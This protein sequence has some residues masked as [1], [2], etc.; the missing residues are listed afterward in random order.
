MIFATKLK[1]IGFKKNALSYKRDTMYGV[2][3]VFCEKRSFDEAI[4]VS[5]GSFLSRIY[6]TVWQESVPKIPIAS[7]ATIHGRVGL[8]IDGRDRWYGPEFDT[9]S[10]ADEIARALDE[11]FDC[12][13]NAQC[14]ARKFEQYPWMMQSPP[15]HLSYACILWECG[16]HDKSFSVIEKV[17]LS[18]STYWSSRAI[19]L[20]NAIRSS[21]FDRIKFPIS[22]NR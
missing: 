3:C 9:I 18:K 13:D 1:E 6:N 2:D 17:C 20:I 7:S 14:I 21:E 19:S 4:T 10:V 11:F 16:L 5:F 15:D 12:D 22:L 8:M